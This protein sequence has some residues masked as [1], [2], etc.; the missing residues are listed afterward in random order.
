MSSVLESQRRIRNEEI[1]TLL[2]QAEQLWS[3]AGAEERERL[4]TALDAFTLACTRRDFSQ[5]S[6][7]ELVELVRTLK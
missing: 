6:N 3:V 4:K 5:W 1:E 2:T 7:A